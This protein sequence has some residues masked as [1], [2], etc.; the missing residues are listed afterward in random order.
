MQRFHIHGSGFNDINT[1]EFVK[2]LNSAY[3][4]RGIVSLTSAK[5]VLG[6]E[7]E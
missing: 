1:F 2:F 6:L 3:L 4:N 7:L 5:I